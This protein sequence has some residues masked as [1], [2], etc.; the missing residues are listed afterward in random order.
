MN[1]RKTWTH[2][3]R[4]VKKGDCVKHGLIKNGDINVDSKTQNVNCMCET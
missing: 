2:T 4:T 1:T 3:A